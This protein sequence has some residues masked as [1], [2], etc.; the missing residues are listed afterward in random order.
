MAY[1]KEVWGNNVWYL[2]HTIAHKI[3]ETEFSNVKND[4]VYLV[5]TISSNLP[6]PECSADASTLLNKVNFNNINNKEEFKKFLFNF[7]NHVNK[8]LNKPLFEYEKLDEKYQKAN[9]KALYHNFNIIFSSNS[10]VHQLMSASF[11]R[12]QNMPK[13]KFVL[14]SLLD[15]M[16]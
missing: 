9:I 10:N 4:L 15:K 8:K 6:C 13:I 1:S 7:H 3:K 11:H 16:D 2:F 14:N 5:N 12:Q